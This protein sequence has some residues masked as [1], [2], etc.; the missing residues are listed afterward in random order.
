MDAKEYDLR[1]KELENKLKPLLTD[2]F[3]STLVRAAKTI[4]WSVDHQE[5]CAFVDYCFETAGKECPDLEPY[6]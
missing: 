2:E 1:E 6:Q 3:L 4:G 5:V